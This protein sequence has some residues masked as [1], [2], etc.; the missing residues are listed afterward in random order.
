MLIKADVVYVLP[1]VCVFLQIILALSK[2]Y[3]ALFYVIRCWHFVA[4]H[5]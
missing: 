3:T 5:K 1:D 2:E 4:I